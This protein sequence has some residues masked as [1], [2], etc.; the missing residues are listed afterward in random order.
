MLRVDYLI[1]K[2]DDLFNDIRVAGIGK[3]QFEKMGNLTVNEKYHGSYITY[4][5]YEFN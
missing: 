3:L 4:R 5:M 1:N 2:I